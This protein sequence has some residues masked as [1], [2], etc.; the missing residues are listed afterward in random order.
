MSG[1][2]T[3]P[4]EEP[5]K[6]ATWKKRFLS[7][8][9][10]KSFVRNTDASQRSPIRDLF[11]TL[12]FRSHSSTSIV[13]VP[14][15]T[16]TEASPLVSLSS[17]QLTELSVAILHHLETH[18]YEKSLAEEHSSAPL[19]SSLQA[20]RALASPHRHSSLDQHTMDAVTKLAQLPE[21]HFRQLA[22]DVESECE[23]RFPD[24]AV[25]AVSVGQK[26]AGTLQLGNRVILSLSRQNH[27]ETVENREPQITKVLGHTRSHSEGNA[28]D[29]TVHSTAQKRYGGMVGAPAVGDASTAQGDLIMPPLRT[30][31]RGLSMMNLREARNA[32]TVRNDFVAERPACARVPS[33]SA[34]SQR[35]MSPHYDHD[36]LLE[37]VGETGNELDMPQQYDLDPD[38]N[39]DYTAK[40]VTGDS[41][42]DE[43]ERSLKQTAP[44]TPATPGP[45]DV[46]TPFTEALSILTTP[47]LLAA[48]RDV[49]GVMALRY[50]PDGSTT[51]PSLPLGPANF[52]DRDSG[53]GAEQP[54][55][56]CEQLLLQLPMERVRMIWAAVADEVERRGINVDVHMDLE[57]IGI[58]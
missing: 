6:P 43:S 7:L 10:T 18:E 11:P 47:Q 51:T 30:V 29:K 20:A 52:T 40:A 50:S 15:R 8:R 3:H 17:R 38:W 28:A 36:Q 26:N 42:L 46:S 33:I 44:M 57:R 5:T 16:E 48:V 24:L 35:S 4:A 41:A 21:D 49:R 45:T 37:A 12:P 58:L 53:I 1:P 39:D 19:A 31:T 54:L 13:S 14:D 32:S 25:S 22:K 55:T 27:E 56:H 23:R 2:D 34:I 9:R